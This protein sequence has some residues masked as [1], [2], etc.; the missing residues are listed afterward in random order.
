M[1]D[2]HV[3]ALYL[4][5]HS[6]IHRMAPQIK[7]VT[8]FLLVIGIVITPREAF[9]AFGAYLVAVIGI[10]AIAGIGP[11]FAGRRMLI[12]IPFLLVAVLLPVLGGEPK[13]E[14]F[15]IALS[16]PGLWDAWNIIAK[17]TFGLAVAV[18]LGATTQV[19]E[20]LAGLDG[21]RMPSIVTAIA[22]FMVRYIDVVMSDWSRMRTAMAS[23]AHDA[24]W[25][26]QIGPMARTLGVMFVRTYE[27]GERVYLAMRSRGYR[28]AM[29]ASSIP[30]TPAQEWAIGLAAIGFVWLIATAALV[31]V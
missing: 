18:I 10:A 11:R 24:R 19:P 2:G 30:A 14:V 5:G 31:G 29:P 23:R 13:V 27:R 4:H 16:E 7:I 8:A 12:E 28:G 6:P 26:T 21:L 3:H 17:A 22:G 15:G 9:W 1:A 25:F 20:F